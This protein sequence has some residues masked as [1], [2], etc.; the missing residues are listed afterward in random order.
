MQNQPRRSILILSA[1]AL[2]CAL[3]GPAMAE[4]APVNLG[5]TPNTEPDI[6]GYRVYRSPQVCSAAGP[7]APLLDAT[8]RQVQVGKVSSY[9]D[10]VSAD[11]PYCYQITAIDTANNES[12]RSNKAEAIVNAVPPSA[13]LNLTAGQ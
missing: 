2:I 9:R 1:L 13:P 7:I 3:T 6:A 4:A 10:E 5:W 8:G 12:L 11:G